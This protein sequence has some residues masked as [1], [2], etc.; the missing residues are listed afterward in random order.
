MK[1]DEISSTPP[2]STPRVSVGMPVYNAGGHLAPSIECILGQTFGDLELIICDNAST[3]GSLDVARAYAAKDKRVRVVPSTRNVGANPN[4]RKAALAATGDYFKWSSSNDLIEP[5]FIESCVNV[6]DSN[7]S[8]VL[9]H[10]QTAIFTNDPRNASLYRDDFALEMDDAVARFVRLCDGLRLNN[11]MNGLIRRQALIQTS[12]MPDYMSS[13]I[14]VLAELAL[15]GKFQLV[16]NVKF[17][18][19]LDESS[20]TALQ[21]PHLVLAHHYPEGG[22]GAQFQTWRLVRGYFSAVR[23]APLTFAQRRRAYRYVLRRAYWSIP[24]LINDLVT[25]RRVSAPKQSSSASQ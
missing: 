6:L 8:A 7:A 16:S 14:V 18:R 19:R 23:R 5:T 4:Y 13:D 3:D 24:G 11:I 10:G 17:L 22:M 2:R 9:C 25:M 12:V 1:A 20:A 15:R 21:A